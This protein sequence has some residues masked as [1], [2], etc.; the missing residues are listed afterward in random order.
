M[1]NSAR[2]YTHTQA[3]RVPAWE[4]GLWSPHLFLFFSLPPPLLPWR[5]VW[6]GSKPGPLEKTILCLNS[7]SWP[8]SSQAPSPT[9]R[10]VL[11][12]ESFWAAGSGHRCSS[13]GTHFIPGHF[14][15]VCFWTPTTVIVLLVCLCLSPPMWP[16]AAPPFSPT[17]HPAAFLFVSSCHCCWLTR[18]GLFELNWISNNA[19]NISIFNWAPG[20]LHPHPYPFLSSPLTHYF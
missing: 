19:I 10:G 13:I 8:L 5:P 18:L 15:L 16:S 11:G 7:A 12:K 9:I 1:D 4:S 17:E 14:P 3:M 20:T 6:N 2:W